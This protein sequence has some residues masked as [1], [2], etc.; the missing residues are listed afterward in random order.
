[1]STF[2]GQPHTQKTRLDALNRVVTGGAFSE[3][4]CITFKFEASCFLV[5]D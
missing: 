2:M 4:D 1:M 3:N 5:S